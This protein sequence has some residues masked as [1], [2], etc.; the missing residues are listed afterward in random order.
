M[1]LFLSAIASS[2]FILLPTSINAISFD[3]LNC[4]ANLGPLIYYVYGFEALSVFLVFYIGVMKYRSS[5]DPLLK[6]QILF[7]IPGVMLFLGIFSAGQIFGELTKLYEINLIGP[8]GMLCFIGV[9]AYM[10]VKYQTFN[11]KMFATQVSEGI[12]NI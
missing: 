12:V 5:D 3:V 7:F 4:Q 2:V 10:I 11:I 6:K 9:L 8:V 1:K